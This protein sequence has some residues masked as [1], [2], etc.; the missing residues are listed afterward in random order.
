MTDLETRLH[1]DLTEA[2]QAA[3]LRPPDREA[4]AATVARRRRQR[5]ARTAALAVAASVVVAAAAVAVLGAVRDDD[6]T[7]TDGP[8][9]TAP[10]TE[11]PPTTSTTTSTTSSTTT[12]AVP[13]DPSLVPVSVNLVLRPD[14]LG[15]FDFGAPQDE[16]MAALVA[17]LGEPRARYEG[18]GAPGCEPAAEQVAWIGLILTFEGPD[19]GS[20]RLTQWSAGFGN[21]EAPSNYRTQDGPALGDPV[22]VWQLAYGSSFQ[23]EPGG[24]GE[25]RTVTINRAGVTLQGRAGPEEPVAVN[26]L[27]RMTTDC[28]M[29]D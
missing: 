13:S 6:R 27:W 29:G 12:P 16:V 28:A 20:L 15:P 18:G 7:V 19:M 8:T 5:R 25:L 2:A 14:G 17:E 22:A 3:D 23:I 4:V 1:A 9:T 26:G 11:V 24:P 10:T 21:P